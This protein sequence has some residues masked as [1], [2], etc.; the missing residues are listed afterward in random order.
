MVTSCTFSGN[1]AGFGG[2]MHNMSNSNPT[3]TNCSFSGNTARWWGAGMRNFQSNSTVTNCTFSSNT[4]Q[5]NGGGG[6]HNHESNTTII[7]CIFWDN[8]PDEIYDAQSSAIVSY[9]DVQG[10]WPG[11]GNIDTDPCFINAAGGDLRLS[12]W[13]SPCIDAGTNT[14]TVGLPLEDLDGHPRIIDSDCSGTATVDMGAY[15]FNYAHISDLDYNCSVNFADF[16]LLATAWNSQKGDFNWN[17]ACD[18]GIPADNY[19]DRRDLSIFSENWLA[20]LP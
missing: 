20:E 18:I 10:G 11:T 15:E 4:V 2:G 8:A 9:S 16:S 13:D 1:N 14:P 5:H 17:F 7:N 3:V 6:M 19:I 12:S